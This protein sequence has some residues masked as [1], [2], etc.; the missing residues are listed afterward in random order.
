MFG[1]L[2]SSRRRSLQFAIGG[3]GNISGHGGASGVFEGG[4]SG[5]AFGPAVSM[6]SRVTQGCQSA[7]APW[8]PAAP[9][10]AQQ[11]ACAERQRTQSAVQLGHHVFAN[12]GDGNLF[13]FVPLLGHLQSKNRGLADL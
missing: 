3:D 9:A 6:V 13:L 1:G 12:S 7:P 5:V 8:P 4:L 2:A 10:K 11:T